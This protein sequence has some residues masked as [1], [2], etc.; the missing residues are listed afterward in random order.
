MCGIVGL[1]DHSLT[2]DEIKKRIKSSLHSIRYRG[3]D[4]SNFFSEKNYAF[5]AVRLSI[6]NLKNG[7]QPIYDS[8]SQ[9][10]LGFNGEIFNYKYFIKKYNLDNKF[11]EIQVLLFLYKKFGLKFL[12]LLEGQF[13]IFIFDIKKNELILAR[14]RFGIRPLYYHVDNKNI[15]FGSEIKTIFSLTKKTFNLSQNSLKQTTLLW[16][17]IRDTTAFEEINKIEPSNYTIFKNGKIIDKKKFLTEEKFIKVEKNESHDLKTLI[18]DSVKRQLQSDV[19]YACYL[20][21]GIDSAVI[22]YI[23]SQNSTQ[24]LDT[25][26]VSF[27][28]NEYDESKYQNLMAKF[29][30]S[31][32]RSI[33]INNKDISD[34]FY[35]TVNHTESLLFRTAPVPMYLLSKLVNKNNHKVVFT[36]EGADEILYGYD[37]FIENRIRRFWSKKTDSKI[38]PSLLKK[39]YNYLPQFNNER[40]FNLT[41]DFY[42]K[43]LSNINDL[44]YSHRV[45]WDQFNNTKMFFNF[46]SQKI[47]EILSS[48]EKDLPMD[49]LKLNV[50]KKAQLLEIKTLLTNYLLCSQ[51]DKVSLA[52]SVEGR[53]PYLDDTFVKSISKIDTNTLA[54]S[55]NGKSLL[56]N[57]FNK[58]LPE[59]IVNRSKFAYQAP[60]ANAFVNSKF[61]S[62]L[63]LDF[64]DNLHTIDFI[65][66]KNFKE[67]IKKIQNPYSSTRLGFRENMSF[68]IGLSMYCLYKNSKKWIN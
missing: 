15:Y 30:K 67:L 18:E 25:F 12:T 66:Q 56:R 13:A 11:S 38:R 44:F 6:E 7:Q 51:G 50:D 45:R 63:F 62:D 22:A 47:D 24:T 39:L 42:L 55:I 61:K 4:E 59:Q 46:S 23:L 41:K 26:S 40:Y 49:F 54:K 20:S 27:Q 8:S 21:G 10:I 14:D 1:I 58:I 65:N 17:N 2:N 16:T 52:N 34:N 53:Y 9:L 68:I 33:K 36:G 64:E 29:L 5:G 60:E 19:G 48:L 35:E 32:H 28:N 37:I 43:T 3:P 57:S 31:N